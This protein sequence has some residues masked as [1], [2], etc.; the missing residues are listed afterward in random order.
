M[1]K[2]ERKKKKKK[3]DVSYGSEKTA[4]RRIKDLYHILDKLSWG[5][6]QLPAAAT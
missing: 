1:F 6:L 2:T 3:E 4:E 5:T